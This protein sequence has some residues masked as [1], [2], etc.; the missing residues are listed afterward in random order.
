MSTI[1][2]P[3]PKT[4]KK[5]LAPLEDSHE[6]YKDPAR[7]AE[8]AG[9]RYRTDTKPALTRQP[10]PDGTFTYHKANGELITDEKTLERIKSFV[11]P[12][13]WTDV[14]I[15][16]TANSH[17]QVT[18]RDAKGRKQYRYHVAWDQARSL[19]KFSRLRAFGEKL[20]DLRRQ[21]QKDLARPELDKAKVMAL[22]LT[23]MDRSY[24]RIGNKEYA[25]ENKTY[26]L[27]TLRDKHVQV[28]G[29]DVRFAFVGKKGV[30][31]DLTIHDRKLARLVQKCKEIP[32]QHLFQYYTPDGKRAELESGDVNEYLQQVTGLALSAK[33][34]RTWGGTVKMVEC[35]ETVINEEPDFPKPKSLK[36]ALQDVAHE[37]GNTPTVC[38]KYYIHPQ[39][40]ELFNTDKLIDYLRRHDADP[41][42][43]DLL[44]P[45]EHMVLDMLAELEG[46]AVKQ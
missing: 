17:L 18:G 37:L 34:F 16:D 21:M 46:D 20:A 41:S 22:V 6:L 45:T 39:V 13:A 40:V 14:W 30:A 29:S 43:N 24:I 15:S 27:T 19:T 11:I 26:G 8:L 9:L 3:R 23:L 44:T 31:H 42:E 36:R 1:A 28:T 25:K 10:G 7:Q 33:D 12:P 35:L 2:Q 32:G 38:S 4:K 5:R